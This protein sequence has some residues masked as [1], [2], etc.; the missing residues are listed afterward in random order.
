[1]LLKFTSFRQNPDILPPDLFPFK[2]LIITNTMQLQGK[3][4]L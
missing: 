3:E 2:L 4:N 1:M